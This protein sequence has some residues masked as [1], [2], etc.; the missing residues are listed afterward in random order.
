MAS[1]RFGSY[2]RNL[3]G[4]DVN[5]L[6]PEQRAEILR[7]LQKD[8]QPRFQDPFAAG[9][10]RVGQG[11]RE[12]VGEDP[13]G[14]TAR[15]PAF[16]ERR[17][18]GAEDIAR[19]AAPFVGMAALPVAAA[20][21]LE[22]LA[23][24]VIG[25]AA[26]AGTERAAQKAGMGPGEASL[27]GTLAGGVGGLF[28]GPAVEG[29]AGLAGTLEDAAAGA[30]TRM[31]ARYQ[32]ALTG[33]RA[34]SMPVDQ[35][36]DMAIWGAAKI[37]R[38]VKTYREWA[39]QMQADLPEDKYAELRPNLKEIWKLS[40]QKYN[41]FKEKS[42]G[43]PNVRRLAEMFKA[44]EHGKDWYEKTY[45]KLQEWFGP[46]A[47]L[48]LDMLAASSQIQTVPGSVTMGLKH[49]AELKEGEPFTGLPAV[50]ANLE[51]AVRREPLEGQ[52]ITSYQ[53]DFGPDPSRVTV[54]RHISRIFGF[55]DRPN[56]EQ[57][58]F[59]DFAITHAAKAEGVTPRQFQAAIWAAYR[60]EQQ[61]G[62]SG[63]T[64]EAII[65]RKFAEHPE[66]LAA[67][68]RYQKMQNPPRPK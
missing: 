39:Q 5:K 64:L 33:E 66:T 29:V 22:T 54:D 36:A 10:E 46:D 34:P 7:R 50:R 31:Q 20:A 63:E 38:G 2:L 58:R 27:L 61:L 13:E 47:D 48:M 23:G 4:V 25:S 30:M 6:T 19:G 18:Q 16:W 28:G 51:R 52:K 49:Y 9:V 43:L 56:A 44:G 14:M 15:D 17:A 21:P 26:R 35:I 67:I 45:G 60:A 1:D 57:Y 42:E 40:N 68:K 62:S 41:T 55:G 12:L 3:S 32:G 65:A 59:A 37:A 11:V 8:N 53:S 24:A